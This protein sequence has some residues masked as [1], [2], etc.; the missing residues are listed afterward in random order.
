MNAKGELSYFEQ[1]IVDYWK[2]NPGASVRSFHEHTKNAYSQTY[3]RNARSELIRAGLLQ[4]MGKG[5]K[6]VDEYGWP[7]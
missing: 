1:L 2:E 4:P 7:I 3:V 6:R 5:N